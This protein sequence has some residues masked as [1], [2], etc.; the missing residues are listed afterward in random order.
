MAPR[1]AFFSVPAQVPFRLVR[2][3]RK[4]LA[5]EVRPGVE[6]VVRAP[7]R[8]KQSEIDRFVES[9]REWITI[10][11]FKPAAKQDYSAEQEKQ[12]RQKAMQVLPELV[13]RY[14]ALVGRQHGRVTITG[15]RTRFGSCSS[16]G[17]LA[18]SYR[19]MAYPL[20][21]IEYVVLHEAAHLK[22]LNHSPAFYSLIE[23]FMPDYK[24]RAKLLK[25]PPPAI[26]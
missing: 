20:E 22:H 24:R 7:M 14:S 9:R 17:N 11:F 18:F 6:V 13:K 5:I 3:Q 16:K 12:L 19:L 10:H 25:Q 4:T 8:L 1:R 26:Q 2:S 15:A 23:R 21:A